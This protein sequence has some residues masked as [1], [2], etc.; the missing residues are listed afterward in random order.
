MLCSRRFQLSV[1]ASSNGWIWLRTGSA[2]DNRS[3][4][5]GNCNTRD[6]SARYA[7]VEP[8]KVETPASLPESLLRRDRFGYLQG[9]R[10]APVSA[11]RVCRDGA[12]DDG[13]D[14]Q[15]IYGTVLLRHE[16]VFRVL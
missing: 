10:A 12:A 13:P 6:L 4:D 15:V 9:H 2:V 7:D 1:N 16:Y 8:G 5:E 14:R 11:Q 3:F